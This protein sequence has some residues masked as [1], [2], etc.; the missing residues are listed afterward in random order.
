ML[1][2]PKECSGCV[3]NSPSGGFS[4]PDGNGTNKVL[5]IGESL[6]QNELADGRPF[7]PHA[8]AG[9]SLQAAITR[10][11]YD[12]NSFIMYNLI[13]CR[14]PFNKLEGMLFEHEAISFCKKA[15]LDNIIKKYKP[16][17]ILALGNLPLKYLNAEDL[18]EDKK[19]AS[20]TSVR[21]YRF[22]SIYDMKNGISPIALVSSLHPSYIKRLSNVYL[23]VLM[24]DIKF[25]ENLQQEEFLRNLILIIMNF[26]Q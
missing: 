26:Q 6:G 16:K 23:G 22:N 9:S 17:V 24:R 13:Q 11:G 14:P 1:R 5:I 10:L 3:L 20:I 12:R 8:E 15:H 19:K 21:G 2:Q 18:G 4:I 25:A 7:R